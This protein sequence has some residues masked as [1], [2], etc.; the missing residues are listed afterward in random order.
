MSSISLTHAGLPDK[1][2][3]RQSLVR[4][5]CRVGRQG[6]GLSDR[7]IRYLTDA[8]WTCREPDFDPGSICAHWMSV[9]AMAD[10]LNCTVRQVHNIECALERKGLIARTIGSGGRRRGVRDAAGKICWVEGVDLAPLLQPAMLARLLECQEQLEHEKLAL[11]ILRTEIQ[12]TRR[13]IRASGD[14]DAMARSDSILPRGRTSRMTDRAYLED[15]L[16]ALRA[17]QAVISEACGAAEISDADAISS[18]ASEIL[19][20][21]YILPRT[22]QNHCTG[23]PDPQPTTISPRQAIL[24]ASTSYQARIERYGGP[25]LTSLVEASCEACSDLGISAREWGSLCSRIGR[26]AAAL[27]ILIVDRNTRLEQDDR[28]HARKPIAC[29]RGI[30]SRVETGR[31]NLRGML[32]AG[33]SMDLDRDLPS[34]LA[35]RRQGAGSQSIGALAAQALSGLGGGAWS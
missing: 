24:L 7:Q 26:E 11:E 4:L 17:V 14:N 3:D 20:A 1:I 32:L 28:Y 15:I 13:R 21:P 31:A 22:S 23:K 5:V 35:Q 10:K 18:G 2:K 34:H 27:T 29:A 6:L 16:E 25:T 12:L 30:A 9:T 8:I 33:Q 19:D